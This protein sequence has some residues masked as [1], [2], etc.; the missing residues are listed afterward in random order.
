MKNLLRNRVQA[1]FTLT[2]LLAALALVSLLASLAYPTFQNIALKVR[3]G[4]GR[5]ALLEAMQQQ[6]RHYTMHNAFVPFSASIA[7]GFK[8][9]SG[10][11]AAAS[12]YE[13]SARAC[14]GAASGAASSVTLD[15]C[16]VIV[17]QP[18]TSLVNANFRDPVCGT[19]TLASNGERGADGD[20]AICWR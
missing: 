8:W 19:L 7:N 4:E 13:L 15:T 17:A 6:E 2:E 11:S 18:G 5:Q 16:V 14:S 3:R 9:H 1:G 10:S 12:A 20:Q